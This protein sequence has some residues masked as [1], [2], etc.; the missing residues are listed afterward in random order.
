[1]AH[2]LG[3]VAMGVIYC[4]GSRKDEMV[5]NTEVK[6][7]LAKLLATE[8]LKVEHRKISTACFDV[9]NRVLMLPI[10][11]TASAT[12]Y[13]LLVGHEVGHALYTPDE[14]YEGAPKDFVNVLEDAR[15]EKMMK[16]TYPGLR[17]SFFEGYRELWN[18]DFFGV[19]ESDITKLPFIDR[20]NLYFKGNTSLEFSVEEKVYVERAANT[21]TFAEVVQLAKELYDY[22]QEKQQEK[23]DIPEMPEAQTSGSGSGDSEINPT[24][25][26]D[27]ANDNANEEKN[28]NESTEIGNDD[29]DL[30]TPSYKTDYD[31]TQSLTE[32]ALRNAL[33]DMVDDDAKEW[34]YLELPKVN[35]KEYLTPWK[36]IQE[37]L[38]FYFNGRA[39]PSKNI[40]D[41]YYDSLN[42]THKKFDEYKKSAQKSVNYLVKQFEMK[43]SADQY[44]RSAISKTGVLDTN[45]LH[46]YRYN[47]D[48]F[49]KVT[50]VPDGKNHGLIMLLDWSG[51]MQSVLMDTLRQTYNLI[52]FCRKVNIPFRVYAFQS[53]YERQ[54]SMQEGDCLLN[55]LHISQ[56]F[57]LLEFFSS[58]MNSKSL[59]NQMKIIWAQAWGQVGHS[60]HGAH[61]TYGLGGTPLAEATMC[62]REAVKEMKALEKVQKV[63]V[64]SLT[65]GEANP[66]SFVGHK[67]HD[68][69]YMEG[70][71]RTEYLCHH[72][73]KI[74]IL[75]DP[76]TGYSRRLASD[77]HKTTAEIVSFHK[78][79]TNYN[80]IGIR[81]CSKHEINRTIQYYVDDFKKQDIYQKQW[82]KDK[83]VALNGETGFTRQFFML[84]QYI[85]GG[86]EDLDVKAKKEVATKAE[87]TRAFKKH[88]NSKL[89]NKTILNAFIEQIA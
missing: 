85:G 12:V 17:K 27:N 86:T 63:N 73:G 3:K 43:K 20:I 50:I 56:D 67:Y 33:E 1:M 36:Q 46:T 28:A 76:V 59:D 61:V 58:Q 79:I 24:S 88:M 16:R 7:T 65:D 4:M 62:M 31:E 70:K 51:S 52:W 38:I 48:I 83:F 37:D 69:T 45:K 66:M 44:A 19:K 40:H 26:E 25:A 5:V 53:G 74:F 34:I 9:H 29:A 54:K 82:S 30:E 49:K 14:D 2:P 21:N 22:A 68:G 72:R 15:I 41:Q 55:T 77:P 75:R 64:I 32:E 78:E 87:L 6:G 84:N 10:W 42:Y 57:K 47:E 8:N 80:W 23:V 81:L 18:Q 39:F 13:D 60:E 35:L 71:Y 11:K 89:T